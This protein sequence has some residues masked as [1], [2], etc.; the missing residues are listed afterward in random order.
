M[1]DEELMQEITL[2]LPRIYVCLYLAVTGYGIP[3]LKDVLWR[4]LNSGESVPIIAS[5]THWRRN[6]I[7]PARV[8]TGRTI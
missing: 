7:Y 1:L 2:D 4:E 5:Q 6:L 8:R 3:V